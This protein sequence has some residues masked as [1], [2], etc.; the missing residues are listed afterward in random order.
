MTKQEL[1][2][3]LKISGVSDQNTLIFAMNMYDI[4]YDQ[5]KQD[6]LNAQVQLYEIP[7]EQMG[8]A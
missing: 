7:N 2:D 6:F 3:M 4:G 5:A 8:R 1:L